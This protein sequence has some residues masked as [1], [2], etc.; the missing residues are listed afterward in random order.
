M[1]TGQRNSDL[2]EGIIW[3]VLVVFT[4]PILAGNFFR[5]DVRNR[6]NSQAHD[7]YAARNMRVS[8][9]VDMV[10]CTALSFD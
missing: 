3:K 10:C 7:Y 6:Q 4:L 9:T 8:D 2:T 5:S 1:I